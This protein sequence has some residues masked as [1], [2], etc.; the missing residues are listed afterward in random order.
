[1]FTWSLTT[2]VE[3]NVG[4]IAVSGPANRWIENYDYFFLNHKLFTDFLLR[5]ATVTAR[6]SVAT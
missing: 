6:A 2:P 5:F 3:W 1:M 4:R